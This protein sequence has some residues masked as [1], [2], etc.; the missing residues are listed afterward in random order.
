VVALNA[1]PADEEFFARIAGAAIAHPGPA[2]AT[3]APPQTT[4]S[5]AL[6][7]GLALAIAATMAVLAAWVLWTVRLRRPASEAV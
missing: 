1:A 5:A 6:P 3:P 2:P 4:P 7:T